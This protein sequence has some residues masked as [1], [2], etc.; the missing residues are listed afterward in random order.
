[1]NYIGQTP[2]PTLAAGMVT[3]DPTTNEL[4]IYDGNNWTVLS[5]TG[6]VSMD[7]QLIIENLTFGSL[8]FYTVDPKNYDWDEVYIWTRETFGPPHD[9][10]KVKET[11]YNKWFISGGVFHFNQEKHRD[12]FVMKW[13]GHADS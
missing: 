10:T 12:W 9:G 4:K 5:T 8:T 3:F 13:S 6:I 11:L 1:M 7:K 2:S